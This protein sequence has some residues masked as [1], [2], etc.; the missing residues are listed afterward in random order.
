MARDK[1]VVVCKNIF[2]SGDNKIVKAA[3]TKRMIELINNL[4]KIE[5]VQDSKHKF[6]KAYLSDV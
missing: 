4:E 5:A 3:F 1:T 2:K 6:V